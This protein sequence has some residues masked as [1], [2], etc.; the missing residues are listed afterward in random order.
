MW[1][2]RWSVPGQGLCHG[3]W[4]LGSLC[5]QIISN[6]GI[7]CVGL[8]SPCVPS[9]ACAIS[10]SRNN[11]KCNLIFMRSHNSANDEF[12]PQVPALWSFVWSGDQNRTVTSHGRLSVWNQQYLSCLFSRLLTSNY[13]SQVSITLWGEFIGHR[14]IPFTKDELMRKVFVTSSW[15]DDVIKW[16][17]FPRYWLLCG[18]F[19]GHRWIPRTKAGDAELWCFLSYAPEPQL[20]KQWRRRCLRRPHAHYD[21]K[22]DIN[23]TVVSC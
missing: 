18:E 9:I 1:W 7:G 10:I 3:C 8:S 5:H 2:W 13:T 23:L 4:C 6:H 22:L 12:I 11:R 15:Y 16:K 19:T 14:W 17:H 21:V 20:S